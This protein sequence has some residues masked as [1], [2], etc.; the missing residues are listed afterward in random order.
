MAQADARHDQATDEGSKP[1]R[2]VETLVLWFQI[3][4]GTIR[5]WLSATDPIL[6]GPEVASAALTMLAFFVGVGVVATLLIW[7]WPAAWKRWL[8]RLPTNGNWRLELAQTAVQLAFW[9][10]AIA[11]VWWMVVNE[12]RPV[13]AGAVAGCLMICRLVLDIAM[14]HWLGRHQ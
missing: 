7:F 1:N 4:L 5:L 11:V 14:H 3:G 6:G 9:A 13:T 10:F 2:W 12:C 8:Q